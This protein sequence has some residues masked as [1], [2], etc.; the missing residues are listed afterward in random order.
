MTDLTKQV[1]KILFERLDYNP[2]DETISG[3][4]I[5]LREPIDRGV[6]LDE[7]V[8]IET[9]MDRVYAYNHNRTQGVGISWIEL[10]KAYK[11]L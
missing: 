4:T 11:N 3:M 5:Y 1:S 8:C 7:I 6:F 10:R 2:P 9:H